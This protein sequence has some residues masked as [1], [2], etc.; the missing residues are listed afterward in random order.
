MKRLLVRIINRSRSKA[1]GRNAIVQALSRIPVAPIQLDGFQ[2]QTL[3]LLAPPLWYGVRLTCEPRPTP[4]AYA[5]C[6][7]IPRVS[8]APQQCQG[9]GGSDRRLHSQQTECWATSLSAPGA[10]RAA[11]MP[12]HNAAIEGRDQQLSCEAP[13]LASKLRRKIAGCHLWWK[14]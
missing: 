4:P 11:P 12:V 2:E 14:M 9:V 10:G 13:K 1:A 7:S 8:H 3:F 5:K 6:T